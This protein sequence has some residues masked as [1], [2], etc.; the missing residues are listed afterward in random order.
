MMITYSAIAQANPKPSKVDVPR[1]SSSMMTSE[2]AVA[3]W[4]FRKE[5][6]NKFR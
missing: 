3:V 2:L 6:I 1:P 4:N 5:K